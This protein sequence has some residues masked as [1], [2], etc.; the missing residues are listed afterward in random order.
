MTI[1][2]EQTARSPRTLIVFDYDLSLVEVDC[3]HYFF[4]KIAPE[5]FAEI[6][7]SLTAPPAS[8]TALVDEMF[9]ELSKRMPNIS[10]AA[11]IETFAKVPVS[12]K[13]LN[14]VKHAVDKHDA[15]VVIIS[16]ANEL[17]IQSM[18]DHHELNQYIQEVHTNRS[19]ADET[20]N[21]LRVKPFHPEGSEPHG[22]EW[23]PSNMCKGK[24]IGLTHKKQGLLIVSC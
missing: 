12:S 24:A 5:L 14:A 3:E 18:L 10:R 2:S 11:V 21:C 15:A 23:C 22:C 17:A 13:T 20:S 7:A 6:A 8:W 19:W 4:A 1:A 16:D 9:V